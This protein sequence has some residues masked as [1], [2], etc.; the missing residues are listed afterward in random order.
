[1]ILWTPLVNKLF[2]K[3]INFFPK[4]CL[5][6]LGSMIIMWWLYGTLQFQL[7]SVNII[8]HIHILFERR[9]LTNYNWHGILSFPVFISISVFTLSHSL[10]EYARHFVLEQ[11]GVCLVTF[12]KGTFCSLLSEE[13]WGQEQFIYFVYS[14]LWK[15]VLW[16]TEVLLYF[17][18]Y[19][20]FAIL[21]NPLNVTAC[22]L[23]N[24][25]YML[26]V[27]LFHTVMFL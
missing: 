2:L 3:I 15:I 19:L 25:T 10:S 16:L 27:I 23:A 18:V 7:R 11:V 14:C 6:H 26:V 17:C 1:M 8:F 13:E 4:N 9:T 21:I 24:S 12:L 22:L 20:M 5:S